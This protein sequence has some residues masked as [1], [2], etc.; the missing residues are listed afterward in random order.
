MTFLVWNL[1]AF[2]ADAL[3]EV[4]KG[5]SALLIIP[6]GDCSVEL[7]N[8]WGGFGDFFFFKAS[9]HGNHVYFSKNV[10]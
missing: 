9:P 1:G 2:Y 7:H 5:K 4:N 6:T 10:S 8:S 3:T